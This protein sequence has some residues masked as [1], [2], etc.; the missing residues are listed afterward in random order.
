MMTDA[1]LPGSGCAEYPDGAYVPHRPEDGPVITVRFADGG[2]AD[3]LGGS[4]WPRNARVRYRGLEVHGLRVDIDV[5]VSPGGQAWASY[6]S[7]TGVAGIDGGSDVPVKVRDSVMALCRK[8]ASEARS[9]L[10]RHSSLP[11][12]PEVSLPSS[13]SLDRYRSHAA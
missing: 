1:E 12:A 11:G 7:K 9:A 3:F 10:R 5:D 13:S 2:Q 4:E 6:T 8:R